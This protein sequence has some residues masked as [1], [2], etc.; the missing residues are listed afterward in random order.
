MHVATHSL[1]AIIWRWHGSLFER[2]GAEMV[3]GST[4]IMI[5]TG[6]GLGLLFGN[7]GSAV[8]QPIPVGPGSVEEPECVNAGGAVDYIPSTQTFF[9]EGGN[10]S[11]AGLANTGLG[12]S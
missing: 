9:C 3:R 4:T 2:G 12:G 7:A 10:D 8:A 11:G 1:T 5:A 6:L